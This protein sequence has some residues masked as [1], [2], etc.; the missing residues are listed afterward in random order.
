MKYQVMKPV[1]ASFACVSE[2]DTL[3]EACA[4]FVEGGRIERFDRGCSTVMFEGTCV[5]DPSFQEPEK[6][7]ESAPSSDMMGSGYGYS[8]WSKIKAFLNKKIW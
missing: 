8:Y 1:G 2:H 6:P 5:Y 3:K 7:V 4:E